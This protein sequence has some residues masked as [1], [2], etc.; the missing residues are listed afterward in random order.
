M[1][2]TFSHIYKYST[3]SLRKGT[4]VDWMVLGNYS[5]GP[6]RTA[7]AFVSQDRQK[8]DC[9]GHYYAS[10]DMW[11]PVKKRRIMWGWGLRVAA[12][13]QQN[14]DS[15]AP[16]IPPGN[17]QTLAREVMW[18]PAIQKLVSPPLE[19]QTQL[20]GAKLASIRNMAVIEGES[21]PLGNI[22]SGLGSQSE[23]VVT[24]RLPSLHRHPYLNRD[25]ATSI[26]FGVVVMGGPD[27]GKSSGLL[28]YID[29]VCPTTNRTGDVYNVE[30]G[31]TDLSDPRRKS[32]TAQ[33]PLLVGEQNVSLRVF[34]DHTFAEAFW[35]DGRVAMI[36]PGTNHPEAAIALHAGFI[37]ANNDR[38]HTGSDV[39][40]LHADVWEVGSIWVTPEEV[41]RTP[42]SS[43]IVNEDQSNSS[44]S[45]F[46][47]G[48][49]H[50]Q[51]IHGE[52]FDLMKPGKYVLL[53]IPRNERDEKALLR[54]EA[55]ARQ[56]GGQ[57]TDM[58]FQE[59]NITGAWASG[60]Q[61]GGLRY[62]AQGVRNEHPQ[63][64]KFGKVELKVAH[65]HTKQGAHYLNFYVKHLGR[66][67]F[68][69][70]GLLGEDDHTE[71]A[72]PS[73]A[74]EH[75]LSLLQFA[76]PAAPSH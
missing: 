24:F 1:K 42:R 56:L 5:S 11:D 55:E 50:L 39:V 9:S 3:G 15:S 43:A 25:K 60:G 2:T 22:A 46:A 29:Y 27:K 73:K 58:Y 10:K 33:L 70:G 28:V 23:T 66:A 31:A 75:R 17:V 32:S 30:V 48:D 21:V 40:V 26:R 51:N 59:L 67:G 41:L 45:P 34:V 57:C 20:R 61:A 49:P 72:T 6:M 47:T 68:A 69:V 35:Q 44:R 52:R 63:W 62:Q 18:D 54:V 13:P 53:N 76:A 71:A 14:N 8:V 65:G 37:S 19:E 36:V 74:C 12:D 7:G 64:L 4:I 16:S 38:I